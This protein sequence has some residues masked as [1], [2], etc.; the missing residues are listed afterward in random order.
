MSEKEIRRVAGKD[1][2]KVNTF[3]AASARRLSDVSLTFPEMYPAEAAEYF[4]S[5]LVTGL[6]RREVRAKRAE[7]GV[8]SAVGMPLG[9]VRSLRRQLKNLPNVLLICSLVLF[10]AFRP[11][12][13]LLAAAGAAAA[14]FF[15]NAFFEYRAARTFAQINRLSSPRV[16]VLREG[17]QFVTDSRSLVPGD[18]IILE[19]DSIVPAD[20][21]LIETASFRV[22]ESPV[23]GP[24]RSVRKDARFVADSK[25]DRLYE[26]MVYAGSVAV[27]GKASAVVCATGKNTRLA[28]NT[29]ADPASALPKYLRN[30]AYALRLV[31][32][33]SLLGCIILVLT[34]L[35]AG[36]EISDVFIVSLAAA[37]SAL[38]ETAFAFTIYGGSAALADAVKNGCV[39]RSP[40]CVPRVAET[41]TVMCC[42]D[43]AF[44][45]SA[46]TLKDVFVCFE[47]LDYNRWSRSNVTDIIRCL[48]LCSS[49]K[50]KQG[51]RGHKRR[52]RRE[53]APERWYE[54]GEYTLAAVEAAMRAGYTVDDA[55]KDFYRIEA[56][57]DSRGE[58]SRVLGLLEGKNVVILRGS[59]ESVLARCAGYR[60]EGT[61]YRLDKRSAERIL[62][63]AS[64]MAR[65]QIPVAVAMGYTQA[66]SL[67]DID[68]ENKL[69][70]LGFAG[71]YTETGLDTASSVYRLGNAGIDIA[72]NTDDAYY[73][74]YNLAESAGI[75]SRED[76][77]CTPEIL[78][79]SD[80][81]LFA[82]DN[83]NYSVFDCLTDAEWL[84]I[85]RLRN[86]AKHKVFTQ[87][88]GAGQADMVPEANATFAIAGKS[89]DALLEKCDVQFARGGF[90]AVETAISRAKLAVKRIAAVCQYMS[91]GYYILFFWC[92]ISLA[93][94]KGLPFDVTCVT[95]YGTL[96]N[97]LL[98]LPLVF[99]PATAKTLYDNS[100]SVSPRRISASMTQTVIYSLICAALCFVS[101]NVLSTGGGAGRCAAF[102]AFSGALWFYSTACGYKG[103][104]VTNLF[105]RNYYFL[106]SLLVA[107]AFA[108][109]PALVPAM[110]RFLGFE[111]PG[112]RVLGASAALPFVLW[113]AL[114][115]ALMF[116]EIPAKKNKKPR[117]KKKR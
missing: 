28:K 43:M 58:A 1:Y 3:T 77:I 52:K 33:S 41:D 75:I 19:T 18:V 51:V 5:D 104:A 65:T 39:F 72:V 4:D 86:A 11:E 59:P 105:Y 42:K 89:K 22:M 66:E 55:K 30:A 34:G 23:G 88:N 76:E 79:E 9:F 20:A 107:G 97:A 116:K 110:T 16:T 96:L 70:F 63:A 74:A 40:D 29:S 68:V 87:I 2:P 113:L 27:S 56:E 10:Y 91:A 60:R 14:L 8:N 109:V 102:A 99:Y 36:V 46:I 49:L 21:R 17:R 98:C 62:D 71:F 83:E 13:W 35:L 111:Q 25:E 80:E 78:H 44:P 67:N 117:S 47:T 53:S 106:P 108:A 50:E 15:V 57:F 45:P 7:Y 84:Y 92:F 12:V 82:E 90:P 85:L 31:S 69:I 103:S 64:Q 48:I 61:N 24:R 95:V 81:G 26:N 54:G 37:C 73:A 6:D 101:A 114:Q 112:L 94:G 38:C 115:S 93:F 100:S 32:V